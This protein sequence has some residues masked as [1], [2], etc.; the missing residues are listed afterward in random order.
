MKENKEGGMR[1]KA[2]CIRE[3]AGQNAVLHS[4]LFQQPVR[5]PSEEIDEYQIMRRAEG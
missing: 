2:N 4:P 1:L 5:G 3:G